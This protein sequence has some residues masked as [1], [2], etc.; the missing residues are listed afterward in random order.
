MTEET[1]PE[2]EAKM[3]VD[4]EM[5]RREKAATT[6]VNLAPRVADTL[7][8]SLSRLASLKALPPQ[9]AASA[10]DAQK[11]AELIEQATIPKRHREPMRREETAWQHKLDDLAAK[12]GAG[13][14]VALVGVQGTGKTQFGASLIAI[15][16]RQKRTA[17]FT[18][19]MDF[20]IDLK[21]TYDEDSKR[22]EAAALRAYLKPSLLVIDEMDERSESAWENRMLF[23]MLNKRY[24]ELKD[25]L[26]I[27]RR[28][29]R[30]FLA[31]IGQ[32]VQSRLQETGGV[33]SFNWP[34]WRAMK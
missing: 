12:L 2:T 10:E 28:D 21:S 9:Q 30:E 6:R 8:A 11:V 14:M 1:L 19:A 29:A 25:T 18:T 7:E 20:F 4:A 17:K 27:S 24:A 34:S 13:F 33:I 3:L 31:S 15:N 26:L 22:N 23:H 32:S 5:R 16:C